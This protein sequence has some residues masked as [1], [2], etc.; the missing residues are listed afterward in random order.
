MQS[1]N[2]FM[3]WSKA[4]FFYDT[5]VDQLAQFWYSAPEGPILSPNACARQAIFIFIVAGLFSLYKL[6]ANLRAAIQDPLVITFFLLLLFITVNLTQTILLGTPYLTSRT[7]L[8]YYVLFAFV[9]I[10]LLR[11]ISLRLNWFMITALPALILLFGWHFCSSL[12]LHLVREWAYDMHTY[13]VQNY[14]KEYL[15]ATKTDTVDLNTTWI[16]NPSFSFYCETGKTPWLHLTDYHKGVD[17]GSTTL[18]YYATYGDATQ[19][20]K[21]KTVLN[22]QDVGSVLLIRN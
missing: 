2:Q 19:L 8:C 13:E 21:Y 1:T 3:Y 22:F 16:Y 6:V 18:F 5:V 12:N 9:F 10:F 7:A 11:F 20:P 15:R 14:L 17:T 4:S